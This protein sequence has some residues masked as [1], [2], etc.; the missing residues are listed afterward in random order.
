MPTAFGSFTDSSLR[1][2]LS[3][4]PIDDMRVGGKTLV[5]NKSLRINYISWNR[6]ALFLL[7][8]PP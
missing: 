5:R 7:D 8:M 3:P 2:Y 1:C 4:C 6:N